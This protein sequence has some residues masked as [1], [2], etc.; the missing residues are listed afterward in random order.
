MCRSWCAAIFGPGLYL[1]KRARKKHLQPLTFNDSA[2]P[3]R[4]WFFVHIT[5]HISFTSYHI[6]VLS[7]PL[8]IIILSFPPCTGGNLAKQMASW[9]SAKPP[10]IGLKKSESPHY[11]R[12]TTGAVLCQVSHVFF[13]GIAISGS[14]GIHMQCCNISRYS[15]RPPATLGLGKIVELSWGFK[16]MLHVHVFP[17][18]PFKPLL[19]Q[20]ARSTP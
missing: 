14:Y 3:V 12:R 20:G 11:R 6:T 5:Y 13:G 18:S 16:F 15:C 4:F 10:T 7:L 2:T 17:I 1:T 8:V 9:T 19:K